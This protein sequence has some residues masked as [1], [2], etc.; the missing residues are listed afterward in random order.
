MPIHARGHLP[1]GNLGQRGAPGG[2][3]ILAPVAV[4]TEHLLDQGYE[5]AEAGNGEEAI[6]HLKGGQT[7]DL[8]FTDVVLPG[9][10]NGVEIAKKAKRL[11]PNIKVLYTT[12]YAENAVVHNGQLDPGVTL[13]NKPY[14][15]AELLEKV[16]AMLDS[17]D[18]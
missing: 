8:L 6:D 14:Q 17:E 9:G 18:T 13:V 3:V 4:P 12:G 10:M 2:A 1:L 16:R 5:V 15:R 11:Q 7:F